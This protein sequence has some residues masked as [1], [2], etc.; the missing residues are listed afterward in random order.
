MKKCVYNV[1]TGDYDNLKPPTVIT[2]KWDYI[3]FT[4]NKKIKSNVW[5]VR[6]IKDD[7]LSDKKLSRKIWI[8]SNRY[9]P[10]YEISVMVG[11][12]IEIKCNL[13]DFIQ[14]HMLFDDSIDISLMKHPNR[15]DIYEEAGKCIAKKLDDP[16]VIKA[17]ID[18]YRKEG[19][20]EKSG[21]YAHGI[22]I[23][24]N[25][26]MVAVHCDLWWKE[27]KK[28]SHRDQLSFCYVLWKHNLVKIN[29]FPYDILHNKGFKRH[30]HKGM[31]R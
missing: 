29:T 2:P 10:E 3:C 16:K 13:D 20:P 4:N 27:V 26:L 15:K 25:N 17:Q 11:G 8:R 21:L 5:D 30:N 22:I 12:Q 24:R 23:R 1:I 7:G 19:Y 31:K 18:H 6:Y 9:V 14:K 28:W